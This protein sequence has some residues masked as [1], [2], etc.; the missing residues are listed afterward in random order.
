LNEMVAG[1]LVGMDRI[2][3]ADRIP[4]DFSSDG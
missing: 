2:W 1:I 3:R 4:S